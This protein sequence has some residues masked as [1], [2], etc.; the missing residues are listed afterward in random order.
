MNTN[1]HDPSATPEAHREQMQALQE[2]M[3]AKMRAAREKKGLLI[4]HTGNGKGKTTA[5]L[6][7]L[8]RMLAHGKKCAV[9]QFIKGSSDA[10]SRLLKSPLLEWHHVGDGFTWDTQDKTADIACCQEGWR[11]AQGFMA[12]PSVDFILLD[13]LNV[14][15][16]FQYLPKQ[17]VL[18]A[19]AAKRADQHIVVTG[20]GA[21]Q[22]LVALA[23]LVSEMK[24][25]KHPFTQGIQAQRGIEY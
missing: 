24:E 18:A 2:E 11:L 1:S 5:A 12:D 22:E 16:E 15:L 14:V 23:D 9:I 21:A 8:T 7:M 19:L 13:E 6:G 20:R 4:V 10:V 3:R 25:I 17:E